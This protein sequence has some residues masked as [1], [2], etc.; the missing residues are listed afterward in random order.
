VRSHA[1]KKTPSLI[2]VLGPASLAGDMMVDGV[3]FPPLM[4]VAVLLYSRPRGL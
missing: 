2:S 3:N 4:K 1:L